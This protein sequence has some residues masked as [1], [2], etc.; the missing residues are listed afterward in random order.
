MKDYKKLVFSCFLIFGV[1]SWLVLSKIFHSVASYFDLFVYGEIVESLVRV[2]PVAIGIGLFFGLYRNEKTNKY[3][4]EVV[5]ELNK[6][7]WPT[8]KTVSAA[9]VAVII[10]VLISAILLFLFDS[11]WS[12]GIRKIIE[13]GS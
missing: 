10:A 11:M 4:T 8:S 1:L 7:T 2:L 9:T 12:Y 13:Y 3:V 5:T 6:V